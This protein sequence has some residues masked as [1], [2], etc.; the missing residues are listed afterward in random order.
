VTTKFAD[1][2]ERDACDARLSLSLTAPLWPYEYCV[3]IVMVVTAYGN[4]IFG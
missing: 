3:T 2:D 4:F 1:R